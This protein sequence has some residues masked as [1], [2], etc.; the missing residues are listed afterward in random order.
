MSHFQLDD[1]PENALNVFGTEDQFGPYR[2]F[3]D[4][5]I[6]QVIEAIGWRAPV[7]GRHVGP[8]CTA[9]CRA[10]CIKF[11]QAELSRR[12]ATDMTDL[13]LDD[14]TQGCKE[15]DD[16]R[17]KGCK[18]DEDED[19]PG[20]KDDKDDDTQGCEDND[21]SR[22]TGGTEKEGWQEDRQLP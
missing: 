16:F 11:K 8:C 1:A 15:K 10:L 9:E 3:H 19:T 2:R 5:H 14:D 13:I 6:V 22:D 4:I 12:F 21:D 20:Y 17:D 7:I 18:E